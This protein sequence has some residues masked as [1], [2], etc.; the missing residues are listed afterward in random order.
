ALV[1]ALARHVVRAGRVAPAALAGF[2]RRPRTRHAAAFRAGF[3]PVRAAGRLQAAVAGVDL[4]AVR[5]GQVVEVPQQ[6]PLRV[7]A[8]PVEA[9]RGG[10]PLVGGALAELLDLAAQGALALVLL[11]DLGGVG[12]QVRRDPRGH[13]AGRV[14]LARGHGDEPAVRAPQD[15][16]PVTPL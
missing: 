6:G 9:D 15:E 2:G 11:F 12:G 10:A 3:V 4:H 16:A 14:V 7:D 5:R 8:G 1:P 13:V